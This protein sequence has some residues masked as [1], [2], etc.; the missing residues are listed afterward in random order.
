MISFLPVNMY[1]Y[2]K[3]F[4]RYVEFDSRNVGKFEMD[5]KKLTWEMVEFSSAEGEA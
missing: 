1:I 5:L 3:P 4:N 2:G